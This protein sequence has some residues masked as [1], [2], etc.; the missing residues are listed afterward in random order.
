MTAMSIIRKV[1]GFL[2]K[3]VK[4]VAK[5][6]VNF[7]KSLPKDGSA[8][9]ETSKAV[10]AMATMGAAV[11]AAGHTVSNTF[12]VNSR[13]QN[14]QPVQP[15]RGA[16]LNSDGKVVGGR[17]S[18]HT[19]NK[20]AKTQL[21]LWEEEL[22][23]RDKF[24]KTLSPKEQKE[25]IK[26][27]KKEKGSSA[28]VDSRMKY[29]MY[30]MWN[31]TCSRA[32]NEL[33][34]LQAYVKVLN[35]LGSTPEEINVRHTCLNQFVARYNAKHNPATDRPKN[36]DRTKIS[37]QQL[38]EY[39]E[40]CYLVRSRFDRMVNDRFDKIGAAMGDDQNPTT[41]DLEDTQLD[42]AARLP[43]S[44]TPII[45]IGLNQDTDGSIDAS[46][47]DDEDDGPIILK[48]IFDAE[49]PD[50]YDSDPDPDKKQLGNI[51]I[52][53]FIP[54]EDWRPGMYHPNAAPIEIQYEYD[55]SEF[56]GR[57]RHP[58]IGCMDDI[59]EIRN[60]KW[61]NANLECAEV[62]QSLFYQHPCIYPNHPEYP[63]FRRKF[64]SCYWDLC[65][66]VPGLGDYGRVL[67]E[68]FV[69]NGAM[70]IQGREFYL[71]NGDLSRVYGLTNPPSMEKVIYEILQFS[72][73]FFIGEIE[74]I[75]ALSVKPLIIRA[76]STAALA[77]LYYQGLTLPGIRESGKFPETVFEVLPYCLDRYGIDTGV[78]DGEDDDMDE[79]EAIEAVMDE[80]A[81]LDD[82]DDEE[83]EL[84]F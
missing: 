63:E 10:G 29:G 58:D 79:E 5:K 12:K 55:W 11:I 41:G 25:F 72:A 47:D 82:G 49:I 61:C 45:Q 70:E 65:R 68:P 28:A 39:S 32:R 50:Y 46:D 6:I 75:R 43:N 40:M 51:S 13:K 64:E 22:R 38:E 16:K 36:F 69:K 57:R 21:E 33:M 20:K 42:W 44:D 71:R 19:G 31:P 2:L 48:N 59:Y 67:N 4:Y 73:R 76:K 77:D 1:G 52:P 3:G 7:F 80:G 66:V 84:L 60:P 62:W 15:Q 74:N 18:K 37:R 26:L 14:P 56:D 23:S 35:S 53:G 27:S 17:N 24:M 81:I 8:V 83:V 34:E 30:H 78:D 9:A 54:I